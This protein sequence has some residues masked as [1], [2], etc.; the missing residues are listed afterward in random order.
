[1]LRSAEAWGKHLFIDFSPAGSSGDPAETDRPAAGP[2]GV[3][4]TAGAAGTA[5]GTH[6]PHPVVHIHLGLIGKFNVAPFA[7]PVGQVRLRIADADE[8][9]AA[10][11]HGPQWCRL[12]SVPEKEAEIAKQGAD[13]LRA[14]ADPSAVFAKV[15]RSRRAIGALLMDQKLFAGVGNIYRAETLFRLGVS[16]FTPGRDV[17]EKVL[18]AIWADLVELMAVGVARGRIDTVRPEHTPE[19]MH[20]APRKDDHG[21]EVYVYRRAGQP[22]LV[23]G[24]PVEQKVLDG[25]NL[26]WCPSCQPDRR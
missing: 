17:P 18:R 14:D 5:A 2:T 11:L 21:G 6:L 24:T 1:M 16:P 20:R 10:D 13:P 15:S 23:C 4:D 7:E 12:L 26:F 22:C 3:D 25:R 19:A 9:V 8:T